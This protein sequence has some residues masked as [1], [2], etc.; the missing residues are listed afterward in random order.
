VTD[1]D[2]EEIEILK[3]KYNI[4]LTLKGNAPL[5]RAIYLLESKHE[6]PPP[7]SVDV[8]LDTNET[9]YYTTPTTWHQSRVI[10]LRGQNDDL[11]AAGALIFAR[12]AFA[13]LTFPFTCLLLQ[14]SRCCCLL[15]LVL[16]L[17]LSP[18]GLQLR[19]R[20]GRRMRRWGREKIKCEELWSGDSGREY[21]FAAVGCKP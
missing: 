14:L 20:G 1:S 12:F 21:R 9:C 5:F 10:F 11:P 7:V 15:C 19:P 8:F 6:L 18:K 4:N 2:L 13:S 17:L 16:S 3:K